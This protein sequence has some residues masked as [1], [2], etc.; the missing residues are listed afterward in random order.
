MIASWCSIFEVNSFSILHLGCMMRI[1]CHLKVN[2]L[3]Q[4]ELKW[5]LNLVRNHLVSILYA[6]TSLGKIYGKKMKSKVKGIQWKIKCLMMPVCLWQQY[7]F[8]INVCKGVFYEDVCH[9]AY[10]AFFLLIASAE[11][12]IWCWKTYLFV[13]S[14]FEMSV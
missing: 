7:W 1:C 10:T 3:L 12:C 8:V 4:M 13:M 6:G 5:Q 14:N 2:V 9:K 11:V